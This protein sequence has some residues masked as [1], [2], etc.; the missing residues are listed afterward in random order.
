MALNALSTLFTQDKLDGDNYVDWKSNLGIVL[1]TD[2]HKQVLFT[3]R[4]EAP[5]K[6]FSNEQ[7]MKYERQKQSNE[8][9]KCY[10]H[11]SMSNLLQQQHRSMETTTD[12][13]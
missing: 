11:G 12:I 1:T 3:P 10:L 9:A 13:M 8:I 2:K 4:T 7:L 5:T 6:E